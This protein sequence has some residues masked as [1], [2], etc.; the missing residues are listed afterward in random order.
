MQLKSQLWLCQ[1]LG[2]T[3]YPNIS[4]IRFTNVILPLS[5]FEEVQRESSDSRSRMRA[6][7]L[8]IRHFFLLLSTWGGVSQACVI[9]QIS[10]NA[11]SD[12]I[13]FYSDFLASKWVYTMIHWCFDRHLLTNLLNECRKNSQKCWKRQNAEKGRSFSHHQLIVLTLS[14]AL[15][16]DVISQRQASDINRCIFP[17]LSQESNCKGADA[18]VTSLQ[19]DWKRCHSK[20]FILPCHHR[21]NRIQNLNGIHEAIQTIESHMRW[22]NKRHAIKIR[23]RSLQ[24]YTHPIC[25]PHAVQLVQK[26]HYCH[27]LIHLIFQDLSATQ[28]I[29]I[30]N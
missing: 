28:N 10:I 9:N 17:Q 8:I 6:A 3:C 13:W 29:W 22:R 24:G 20:R 25:H 27:F 19:K 16:K 26:E 21:F 11:A 2:S 18:V 23:Y 15:I 1:D 12:P 4:H 14:K 7:L 5:Q 30:Q